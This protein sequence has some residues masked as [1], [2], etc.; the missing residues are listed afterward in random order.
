MSISAAAASVAPA[1]V[2]ELQ[3]AL[4]A[5]QAGEF[6]IGAGPAPVPT[7]A[8]RRAPWRRLRGHVVMV[9][10]CHGGAGASILA[11]AVAQAAGESGASVRLLDCAS[12]EHSGLLCAPDAELG[13][14]GNGW[15]RGRRGAL[16]IDRVAGVLASAADVPAPSDEPG[17][18][19]VIVLDTGWG[20]TGVLSGDSWLAA[21][22][23]GAALVLVARAT[24]PGLRRLEQVLTACPGEPVVALRGRWR[25]DR[26][27]HASAGRLL[28][29]AE[30][31]G[32]VVSVPSDRHLAATG[33]TGAPLP[34]AVLAAGARI[35]ACSGPDPQ[36]PAAD[37]RPLANLSGTG[38]RT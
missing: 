15:R 14:D 29:A 12:A 7:G 16:P 38:T 9:Q 4:R 19:G 33:I 37:R 34:R 20:A 17:R 1:T 27:V 10:G 21:E 2:A 30:V 5:A 18:A 25:W 32:R 36:N 23:G 24:I 11:L 35:V 6:R 3:A 31:A 8:H 28:L 13:L 26:S 22:A